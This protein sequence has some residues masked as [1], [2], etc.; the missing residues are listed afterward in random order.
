[1]H[2]CGCMNPI[3]LQTNGFPG[4]EFKSFATQSEAEVYLKGAAATAVGSSVARSAPVLSAP[5]T[6]AASSSSVVSPLTV[7]GGARGI[8]LDIYTDGACKGNMHVK[9]AQ[10]LPSGWGVSVCLRGSTQSFAELHGP[11]ITDR[12]SPFFLGADYS[13]NNTAELS[14]LGEALHWLLDVGL[15][16]HEPVTSV[17]LLLDSTYVRDVVTGAKEAHA[18]RALVLK[19]R[20][21]YRRVL[22]RG[23]IVTWEH[24][25]GHSGQAGN[26]RA[27]RLANEGCMGHA[28]ELGRYHP[29][30]PTQ[31]PPPARIPAAA[32]TTVPQMYPARPASTNHL[33]QS[34][35]V[36][37]G[38]LR[39]S[40]SGIPGSSSS[41]AAFRASSLSLTPF[42]SRP[43]PLEAGSQEEEPTASGPSVVSSLSHARASAYVASTFSQTKKRKADE[44]A[45]PAHLSASTQVSSDSK[46][47]AMNS[48]TTIGKSLGS[49]SPSNSNSQSSTSRARRPALKS[50]SSARTRAT[51]VISDDEN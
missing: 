43:P 14:A 26:E 41:T 48:Q 12:R 5:R 13:S 31:R 25:K 30:W 19:L 51:I 47:S 29:G 39:A 45:S 1:M 20:E 38:S 22:Q 11:V 7:V 46:P 23:V 18:N 49:P 21:L 16:D 33:S 9:D 42:D 17:K 6:P 24:V 4:A 44:L 40:S 35:G 36:A 15:H 37:S 34:H 8:D 3:L 50:E 27:D 28:C 10:N 32:P 2:L